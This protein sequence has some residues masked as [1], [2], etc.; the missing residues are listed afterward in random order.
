MGS[1]MASV[2]IS[3][4]MPSELGAEVVTSRSVQ[5]AL[6]AS[7]GVRVASG[8]DRKADG[9]AYEDFGAITVALFGTAG[10]VAGIKGIFEVI[11][12]AIIEAHKTRREHQA[13]QH[14]LRKLILVLGAR[15][16]E[17]D[18]DRDL[19]DIERQIAGLEQEAMALIA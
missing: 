1:A 18:L 5:A 17:V 10:A 2:E 6:N 13:Q 4:S 14:E 16:D 7:P 9:S 11:R 8:A 3:L 12:T 19:A 15:R